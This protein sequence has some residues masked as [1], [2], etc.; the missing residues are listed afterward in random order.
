MPLKKIII[1]S[2]LFLIPQK[3]TTT[4]V[5]LINNINCLINN[6]VRF[7]KKKSGIRETLNLL[8][9]A[10]NRIDTIIIINFV[11]CENLFIRLGPELGDLSPPRPGFFKTVPYGLT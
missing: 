1:I 3:Q 2:V 10:D 6:Q 8:T 4:F 7:S 5:S 9:D 11:L